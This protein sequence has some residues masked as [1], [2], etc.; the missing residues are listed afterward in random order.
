MRDSVRPC[1][2]SIVSSTMARPA[3]YRAPIDVDRAFFGKFLERRMSRLPQ[4]RLS[5]SNSRR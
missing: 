5:R 4:A 1:D 2:T 3:T